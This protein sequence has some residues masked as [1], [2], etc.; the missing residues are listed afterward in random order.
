LIHFDPEKTLGIRT[1]SSQW[2]GDYVKV[3]FYDRHR[4]HVGG[5]NIDFLHS[6]PRYHI[7]WCSEKFTVFPVELPTKSDKTWRIT[8][9]KNLSYRILIHCNG[10]KVLDVLLSPATC[11]NSDYST[12]MWI[13]DITQLKF[14]NDDTASDYYRFFNGKTQENAGSKGAKFPFA[15][16]HFLILGTFSE[17]ED[18]LQVSH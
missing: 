5:V 3:W 11:S 8:V 6:V 15:S 2:N 16:K 1:N 9:T 13:R 4:I 17:R 18:S 10:V 12:G 7:M 14:R